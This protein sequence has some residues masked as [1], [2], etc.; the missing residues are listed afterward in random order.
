MIRITLSLLAILLCSSPL[1]A[2][3]Y[4]LLYK[5]EE[6]KEYRFKEIEETSALA[7]SSDG[8]GT[9]I[10]RRTIRYFTINVEKSGSSGIQYVFVQDTAIVEES[11]DDAAIRQQYQDFQNI[12]TQK[13]IRVRQT[14]SGQVESTTALQPLNAEAIFGRGATDAMFTQRAALFPSLPSRELKPG[15]SWSETQRDTLFPSKDIPQV[16]RGTGVRYLSRSTEYTIGA[17]DKKESYNCLKVSWE[18]TSSLEEKIIYSSLEEFTE[19]HTNTNGD[20][21]I[22][23]DSGLPVKLDVYSNQENTRALFGAQSNVVPSSVR[24]HTTLELFSQ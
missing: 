3:S 13:P 15:L 14:P 23:I 21:F 1:L 6:G 20:L 5:L 7:Q 22:D 18:G 17:L 8:R 16:G 9:Q 11:G 24:T 2:Q 4:N 19:D 10:D 12:I